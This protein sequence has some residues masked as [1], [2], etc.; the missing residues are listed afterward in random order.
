M[1]ATTILVVTSFVLSLVG[2]EFFVRLSNG[3]RLTVRP[4]DRGSHVVPTPSGGGIVVYIIAAIALIVHG[5]LFERSIDLL[6]FLVIGGVLTVVGFLDDLGHVRIL[7]R[8]ILHCVAAAITVYLYLDIPLSQF[9]TDLSWI[10]WTGL[11][12]LF[13]NIYNFL[14]GSDGMVALQ[15][16]LVFS[17]WFVVSLMLGPDVAVVPGVLLGA[18]LGFLVHNWH[19]ARLFMGD[20]GSTFVGYSVA[21]VP[22]ILKTSLKFPDLTA[23]LAAMALSSPFIIDGVTTRLRLAFTTRRFWEPNRKHLYQIMIDSGFDQRHVALVYS[24]ISLVVA[25]VLAWCSASFKF[26]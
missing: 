5:N 15:S 18:W 22:L 21:T 19:P 17:F 26:S 20:A 2:V 1:F 13:I 3:G 10:I 6:P 4:N 25:V 14:D 11:I 24:S 12:V 9:G 16:V 7:V 23:V 8:L